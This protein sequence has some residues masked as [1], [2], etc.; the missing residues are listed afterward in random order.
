MKH[1]ISSF[2]LFIALGLCHIFYGHCSNVAPN[3]QTKEIRAWRFDNQG[4]RD[5]RFQNI[6]MHINEMKEDEL[7]K[8][9]A[10]TV[11]LHPLIILQFCL[12]S[13]VLLNQAIES[14]L[15]EG[16]R[17]RIRFQN[18]LT[19]TSVHFIE[20]LMRFQ[21][22]SDL[23]NQS[24]IFT[25]RDI[26][27]DARSDMSKIALTK[28]CQ[29]IAYSIISIF[30]GSPA[31][32]VL[33]LLIRN[34]PALIRYL[35]IVILLCLPNYGNNT[36]LIDFFDN[37]FDTCIDESHI[38]D[39]GAIKTGN[40]D[41]KMDVNVSGGIA[42]GDKT[43]IEEENKIKLSAMNSRTLIELISESLSLVFETVILINSIISLPKSKDG[44]LNPPVLCK[45]LICSLLIFQYVSIRGKS[46][47]TFLSSNFHDTKI[48]ENIQNI[49]VSYMNIFSTLSPETLIASL[50][51]LVPKSSDSGINKKSQSKKKSKKKVP[52]TKKSAPLDV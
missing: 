17:S 20:T 23:E 27:Q 1:R 37:L 18:L 16:F 50:K 26:I 10:A 14:F 35:G 39:S 51:K 25:E 11:R 36:M 4:N 6:Y 42:G 34:I 21:I 5:T 2:V 46:F 22:P 41:S 48:L 3:I 29:Q 13:Y 24:G 33:P 7:D 9:I 43:V 47:G 49:L 40:M 19:V 32:S 28:D 45:H 38:V 8:R 52:K 30:N 12:S 31:G 15:P 44:K